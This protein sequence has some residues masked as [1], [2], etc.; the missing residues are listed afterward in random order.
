MDSKS[1]LDLLVIGIH[2]K[3]PHIIKLMQKPNYIIAELNMKE[4]VFSK[5]I[6]MNFF[7]IYYG[8]YYINCQKERCLLI[9]WNYGQKKMSM[10]ALLIF[11]FLKRYISVVQPL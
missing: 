8:F 10:F 2:N 9:F 5:M 7:F 3:S 11:L 6:L 4:Y 1:S